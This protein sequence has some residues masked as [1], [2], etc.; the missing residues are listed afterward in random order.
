MD[1]SVMD[2]ETHFLEVLRLGNEGRGL[3]HGELREKC[4]PA[5]RRELARTANL[6]AD[7]ATLAD[8]RD[9]VHRLWAEGRVVVEPPAG[10]GKAVRVWHPDGAGAVT[11]MPGAFPQP[12]CEPPSEEAIRIEEVY[13]KLSRE[14]RS[15]YVFLSH[16][17]KETGLPFEELHRFL[18][19]EQEAGRAV[20]SIGDW[21]AATE[22]EQ[23]AVLQA[24]GRNYIKVRLVRK[25]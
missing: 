4:G 24:E 5:W 13:A 10:E 12:V 19:R 8:V 18:R 20:L 6:D 3:T 25:D 14:E 17:R 23:A 7:E 15:P 11:S 22:E 2:L 21:A 16:L 9:F 1:G